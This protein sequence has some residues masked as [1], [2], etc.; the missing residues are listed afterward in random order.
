MEKQVL[1]CNTQLCIK[2]S[3]LGQYRQASETLIHGLTR[4]VQSSHAPDLRLAVEVLGDTLLQL[5]KRVAARDVVVSSSI[6]EFFSSF[7]VLQ[8]LL[9]R[10][11]LTLAQRTIIA[12]KEGGNG[13]EL[14]IAQK[15]CLR[16]IELYEVSK[17]LREGGVLRTDYKVG[18]AWN[19]LGKFQLSCGDYN[20]A[21]GSYE[22]G[23]Q[24]FQRHGDCLNAVACL[25]NLNHLERTLGFSTTKGTY[26]GMA[27][28]QPFDRALQHIELALSFI[29]GL[30]GNADDKHIVKVWK[31]RVNMELAMTRLIKGCRLHEACVSLLEE[32]GSLVQALHKTL[33]SELHGALSIYEFY[34]EK[35][36]LAR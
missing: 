36:Q 27:A 5:S 24:T 3:N 14:E 30:E 32:D 22:Q 23:L 17:Q 10:T 20:L 31:E 34:G 33:A 18:N 26:E 29:A 8:D 13:E 28:F 35:N 25:C 16:A 1:A 2:R 4:A 9:R 6:R 12:R 11:G 15:L 7:E 19:E 21:K